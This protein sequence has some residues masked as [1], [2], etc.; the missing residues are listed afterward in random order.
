MRKSILVALSLMTLVAFGCSGDHSS[1]T[2]PTANA[3]TPTGTIQGK[4]VDACNQQPIANAVVDIGLAKA[5]TN[6]DGQYTLTNVPATRQQDSSLRGEYSATI[7][8]RSVTNAGGVKFA[9]GTYPEFAYNDLRVTFTTLNGSGNPD[10]N[11]DLNVTLNGNN[12]AVPVVGVAVGNQDL[13]VGQLK[14][15]LKGIVT[16]DGVTQSGLFVTLYSTGLRGDEPDTG[17][18]NRGNIV[19]TTTTNAN[20]VYSFTGLETNRRFRVQVSNVSVIDT[21]TQ[22]PTVVY[23]ETRPRTGCNGEVSWASNIDTT[24]IISLALTSTSIQNS[25][26]LYANADGSTSIP[27]VFTFNKPI[28]GNDNNGLLPSS[29]T[30]DPI[31][32]LA[33]TSTGNPASLFNKVLVT[34]EG[35]KGTIT[36]HSLRWIDNQNLEVTVKNVAVGAIYKVDI[37]GALAA[38]LNGATVASTASAS[39]LFYTFGT[40]NTPVAPTVSLINSPYDYNGNVNGFTAQL[41]WL[42]T[43]YSKGYNIY[44]QAVQNYGSTSETMAWK[45]VNFP[46]D[47]NSTIWPNT[48]FDF[49]SLFFET[50]AGSPFI[51]GLTSQFIENYNVKL[52]YNCKVNGVNADG[53]EGP[54]SNIVAVS[55]T[56]AP[57]VQCYNGGG[58]TITFC[59]NE[60]MDKATLLT[61]ANFTF[62]NF[63]A[64]Y[65]VP[66]LS[67]PVVPLNPFAFPGVQNTCV[68]YTL[69]KAIDWTQLKTSVNP[70]PFMTILSVKD[71]AGIAIDSLFNTLSQGTTCNQP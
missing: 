22:Q 35:Y 71:V 68:T 13:T 33:M 12:P 14:A 5:T 66:K 37:T 64:S 40:S 56:V 15:V 50:Q 24:G 63:S 7:D 31:N 10:N 58:A 32:N 47:G 59:F 52:T 30:N 51:N 25:Q 9:A 23:G 70:N 19:A 60:P 44:C 38:P 69:D 65:T 43:T 28:T 36:P 49:S 54:A 11:N 29:T 53:T 62:S 39:I 18:G 16:T 34:F 46:T 57:R 6:S 41:S 27:V 3:L 45:K 67:N 61:P 8:L 48:T 2:N 26:N 55:D 42:P 21:T 1:V 4:L 20:G 17:I